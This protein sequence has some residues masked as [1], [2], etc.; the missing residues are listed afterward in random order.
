MDSQYCS[1][2]DHI[3]NGSDHSLCPECGVRD[4]FMWPKDRQ[5]ALDH[6][7]VQKPSSQ[8]RCLSCL[9]FYSI[10]IDAS[11]VPIPWWD[12]TLLKLAGWETPYPWQCP[13]CE[14]IHYAIPT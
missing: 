8:W 4:T 14:S 3:W 5:A 10:A 1:S 9:E 11:Q 7:R 2:C 13:H 12:G 6:G